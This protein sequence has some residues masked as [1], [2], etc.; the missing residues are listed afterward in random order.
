MEFVQIF[1]DLCGFFNL[2]SIQFSSLLL[3][4]CCKCRIIKHG[5]GWNLQ[6]M[7]LLAVWQLLILW[8]WLAFGL[9]GR[10]EL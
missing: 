9:D 6:L 10:F 4:S 2:I 1:S 5:F 8:W 7:K 3:Y